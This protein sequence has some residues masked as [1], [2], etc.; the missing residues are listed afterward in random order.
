MDDDDLYDAEHIRDL[1]VA[2]EYS[3]AQLVGKGVECVYLAGA[4]RT[5]HCFRDG[6]EQYASA[7][8]NVLAGGALLIARHDLERAGGWRRMRR[9]VDQAL[10]ADVARPAGG[11][12][13]HTAPASRSS[14][15][16]AAT[17][18]RWRTPTFWSGRTKCARAGMRDWPV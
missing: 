10:I 14:G 9:H 3:G 5:V 11:Y 12:T 15:T 17:P 18:G 7:A 6:G 8:A 13:G 4:N 1:V 16:G 2:H